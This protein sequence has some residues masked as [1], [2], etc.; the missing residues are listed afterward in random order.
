MLNHDFLFT[1]RGSGTCEDVRESLLERDA[2]LVELLGAL[3]PLGDDV[4]T[5]DLL[6]Q[7]AGV[8]VE[9]DDDGVVLHEVELLHGVGRHV[10]QAVLTLVNNDRYIVKTPMQ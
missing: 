9:E 4:V 10:Q 1:P 6:D 2:R 7:G 3:V 5:S 8:G